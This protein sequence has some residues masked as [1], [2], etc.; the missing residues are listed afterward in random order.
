[1]ML[2]A[3]RVA[4]RVAEED[5]NL[6][7]AERV[8]GPHQDRDAEPA[9][10]VAGD[11]SDRAAAPGEQAT[12]Q[13]VGREGKPV[14]GL[15]HPGAGFGPYLAA[16]VQRLRC[17]GYRHAGQPRDVGEGRAARPARP[18]SIPI[19]HRCAPIRPPMR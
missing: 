7:G 9:L 6:A 19:G 11:Q 18:A 16:A 5:R 2:F 13:R 17:G 4:A 14:G 15:H 8:L 3:N 10:Q 1:M 12:S